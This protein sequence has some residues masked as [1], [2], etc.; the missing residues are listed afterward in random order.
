MGGG[1]AGLA[2]AYFLRDRVGAVTVLEGSSRLG[3]KLA[4]S[5]VAGLAVD[6]GAEAL[7]ARRP[8]AVDLIREL[9]LA[10]Q[11]VHPGT[12]T[13]RIWT[14][15]EFRSLPRRQFMGVPGDFDELERTRI[16]SA[17]GVARAREDA[18]LAPTG[19]DGDVSVAEFVGA[20]LGDEVVDRLVEPLLGGVYAGRPDQLSYDATLPALA[21]ASLRH[22]ALADAVNA[23]LG[24]VS[25]DREASATPVFATLASGLGTLP[26]AV[27]RASGARVRTRAT[28]R[29]LA[30]IADGWRLTVGPTISPQHVDADAVILALPARPASRLVGQ[31]DGASSVSADLAAVEYA[32]MAIVTLAYPVRAFGQPLTGS[33]YLVPAVDGKPV[34]AAT[35]STVKW[36]HLMALPT[37]SA[38]HV[39]RCSI[40]RIGEDSVLQRDD[41]DLIKLAAADFAAATG[42]AGA[43]VDARVTRWGGGLPQYTVGHLGR[44]ARIRAGLAALGGL[45]ACGAA[46]DGIG[47]PACIASARLAADQAAGY[48]AGLGR[49]ANTGASTGE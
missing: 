37:T 9:G 3:G 6:S 30:R 21:Q 1:I 49:I 26:E 24:P 10:D 28:V 45:A 14:R 17:A 27:A 7:L 47:V 20:R 11:L 35:F 40:G 42:V 22:R 32:S 29:E 48:V 43:P 33:G 18:V 5:E 25:P 23:L 19:R 31:V 39:V 41:A 13:A 36:P 46:Y 12:T 38:V 16:V 8:E 4:I 2:A 15:G 34:K 44:V